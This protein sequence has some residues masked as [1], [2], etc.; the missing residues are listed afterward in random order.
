MAKK[1]DNDILSIVSD[2]DFDTKPRKKAAPAAE[3]P[4]DDRFRS[5]SGTGVKHYATQSAPIPA[6]PVASHVTFY[7]ETDEK[8]RPSLDGYETKHYEEASLSNL[9]SD[10][11]KTI[12]M[13][14]RVISCVL[15]I[16]APFSFI[17]EMFALFGTSE[18]LESSVMISSVISSLVSAILLVIFG[19]LAI[20]L[21][22]ILQNLMALQKKK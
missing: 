19:F 4:S 20:A 12:C 16:I 6:A 13:V 1:N 3:A 14:M 15:F 5:E 17:G 10:S 2:E 9:Y 22:K 7:S 21:I 11:G 18:P 8:E